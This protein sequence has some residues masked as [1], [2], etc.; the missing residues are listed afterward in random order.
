M[1]NIKD[2][3]D[4]ELQKLLWKNKKELRLFKFS[5]SGAKTKNTKEGKEI[6]KNIAQILTEVNRRK[7]QI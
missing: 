2:K 6:R 5:L 1:K 3:K 4:I 7:K